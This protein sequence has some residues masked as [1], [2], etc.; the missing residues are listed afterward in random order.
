MHN[1][2]VAGENSAIFSGN[3]SKVNNLNGL[4]DKNGKIGD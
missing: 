2:A 1:V 4:G 3:N